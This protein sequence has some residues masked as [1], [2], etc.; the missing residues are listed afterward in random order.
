M[1]AN[2]FMNAQIARY[3]LNQNLVTAASFVRMAAFLVHQFK[4]VAKIV[5][6]RSVTNELGP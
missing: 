2:G 5:A 6:A 1:H 4:K 3:Y